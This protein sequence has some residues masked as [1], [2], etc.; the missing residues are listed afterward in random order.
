MDN[1]LSPKNLI[2]IV[3]AVVVASAFSRFAIYP[4][5]M[6]AG[7]ANYY[8]IIFPILLIVMQ[9]IL[10]KFVSSNSSVGVVAVGATAGYFLGV[11]SCLVSFLMTPDGMPKT[12]NSIE[13]FGVFNI[14]FGMFVL[15][16]PLLAGSW[17]FGGVT[18]LAMN[19]WGKAL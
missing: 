15:M 10:L 16:P 7:G 14:S 12:I 18:L 6:P 2:L 3:L 5:A 1:K 11:I 19:K 9:P 4:V 13:L 17:F 8:A